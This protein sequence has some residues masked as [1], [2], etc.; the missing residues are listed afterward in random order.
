M[1]TKKLIM[2][3]LM[4][5]TPFLSN[6]QTG[7]NTMTPRS[8]LEVNGTFRVDSI[9]PINKPKKIAVFTD[10]NTLD[11]VS[12]DTLQKLISN[13][14]NKPSMLPTD[15]VCYGSSIY[16]PFYNNSDNS[17]IIVTN[18]SSVCFYS[19]EYGLQKCYLDTLFG[20]PGALSVNLTGACIINNYAYLLIRGYDISSILRI[21]VVRLP[22]STFSHASAQIM[23]FSGGSLNGN[24]FVPYMTGN[25]SNLYFNYNGGYSGST[26]L[27]AKYQI[28]G[29]TLS[30]VST[31]TLSGITLDY[32]Y[33][34]I[35]DDQTIWLNDA[36]IN[37]IKVFN[38]T[39]SLVR[40]YEGGLYLQNQS[41]NWNNV[42]Y[43]LNNGLFQKI[44]IF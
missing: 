6:G 4:V 9:K 29:L 30:K 22:I 34:F 15:N 28:S 18:S 38:Q 37:Y 20:Y 3:T 12:T 19:D 23:S 27:I 7:V 39:G 5:M 24:S 1:T 8:T 16:Y 33:F 2:I 40:T 25:G 44:N 35:K 26:N 17:Y 13:S 42:L 21:K 31:I 41:I 32:S 36:S 14:D 10:S 43:W 11:Y